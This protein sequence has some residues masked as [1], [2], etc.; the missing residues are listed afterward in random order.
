MANLK[1][2]RNR[3]TSV[4]STRQ[5]TSAMKMVS[6]AKLRRAQDAITQM[7]PYANKLKE[8]LGNLSDGTNDGDGSIYEE[9]REVKRVLLIPI[10][11]NRGLAGAFNANIIKQTSKI[12]NEKY[13][14]KDVTVLAIGKKADDFFKKTEYNIKGT[15][16]PGKLDTIFDDLNFKRVSKVAGKIMRAFEFKQFDEVV[17]IYNEFVNAAVQNVNVE[18][19]MPIVSNDVEESSVASDYIYEPSKEFIVEELIPKSIKLQLFKALLDS[20]ASEHGARMTAMHK[21]T[22]NASEMIND[23]K[24]VYN[25]ARQASITNE[26]LEIVG[27]A[28]ALNN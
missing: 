25:K 17:I 24:L 26:I 12:I 20:H 10:T 13:A 27:G 21:A 2:I 18:Q 1:E 19:M 22:D 9:Q 14:D 5:I 11:S 16:L 8:L 28:E 3:I 7:R 6:A 23:L 15:T 4:S